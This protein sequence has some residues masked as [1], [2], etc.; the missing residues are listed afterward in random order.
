MAPFSMNCSTCGNW[1]AKATKF[2]ARKETAAGM[3]YLGIRVFRFY[4]RCPRCS[5]EITFRTDPQNTDYVCEQG[6]VRNF[7]PW[8]DNRITAEEDAEAKANEEENNPMKALENRTAESKREMDILDA[9]DEIRTRNALNER[10]DP[11][12]LLDRMA[13]RKRRETGL[14]DGEILAKILEEEDEAYAK[15]VFGG[16]GSSTS[17]AAAAT[18]TAGQPAGT[19]SAV[20]PPASAPGIKRIAPEEDEEDEETVL[21]RIKSK[22]GGGTLHSAA[23]A[24]GASIGMQSSAPR[25]QMPLVVPKKAKTDGFVVPKAKAPTPA[26]S[27]ALGGLAA[28]ADSD[29]DGSGS[30]GE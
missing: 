5:A 19:P 1:I 20:A 30:G 7:E 28:Y 13:E 4:I 25:T 11:E 18:T 23:A 15:A 21:K 16:G 24:P 8:K 10:V 6:A 17:I 29:E 26:V 2:N 3:E 9:L 22:F 12:V 27:G 14:D